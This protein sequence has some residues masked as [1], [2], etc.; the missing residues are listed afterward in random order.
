MPFGRPWPCPSPALFAKLLPGGART[1]GWPLRAGA[2]RAR[3]RARAAPAPKDEDGATRARGRSFA[4]RA[5]FFGFFGF[6]N[7]FA[8]V[9]PVGH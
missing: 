6:L 8:Y 5:H 1:R 7:D 4:R 3:A 9:C 2:A